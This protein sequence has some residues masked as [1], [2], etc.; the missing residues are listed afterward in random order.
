MKNSLATFCFVSPAVLLMLLFLILPII[1][2]II[3]SF[4]DYQLGNG[5]FHFVGL[6]N[7]KALLKDPVFFHFSKKY[8]NLRPYCST[9]KRFGRFGFSLAYRI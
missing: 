8:F 3:L 5:D 1:W 9:F 7:Y 2:V 4:S 6:I